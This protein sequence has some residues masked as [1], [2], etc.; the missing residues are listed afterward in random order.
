M[1]RARVNNLNQWSGWWNQP[2]IYKASKLTF[3]IQIAIEYSGWVRVPESPLV[4]TFDIISRLER[5]RYL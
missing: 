2:Q 4:N 3:T 1:K 5:F